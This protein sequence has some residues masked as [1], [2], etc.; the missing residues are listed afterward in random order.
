MLEFWN[1][2]EVGFAVV[3]VLVILVAAVIM[4]SFIGYIIFEMVTGRKIQNSFGRYVAGFFTTSILTTVV[5]GFLY[6]IGSLI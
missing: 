2:V 3:V 6:L 4:G 5:L 1:T